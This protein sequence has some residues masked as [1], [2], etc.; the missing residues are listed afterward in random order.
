MADEDL[1]DRWFV[2]EEALKEPVEQIEPELEGVA[3]ELAPELL[4]DLAISIYIRLM[5]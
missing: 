5:I 3:G 4:V 2:R 1:R